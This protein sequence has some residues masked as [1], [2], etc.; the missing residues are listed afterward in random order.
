L[1]AL[2]VLTIRDNQIG[3]IHDFLAI[4]SPQFPGF[5]LPLSL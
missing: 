5:D 3:E 4:G 2:Q 1:G